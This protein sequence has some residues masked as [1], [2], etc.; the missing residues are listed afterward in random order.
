MNL[1]LITLQECQAPGRCT[2]SDARAAHLRTFLHAAPG[3][4]FRVG[5]VDGPVGV[6]TVEAVEG[7]QVRFT[8]ACS[9]AAPA[10]WY[11]LVLALP[12]PRSLRRILFQSAAMGVRRIWLTGAAKVE[13]SYF[14]MH[15]LREAEYRPILLEG[16]MQ[17][18]ATAMP[19]L[20]VVPR[21][22]D[23][24]DLLPAAS[25]LRIL[26]NPAPD[27]APLPLSARGTEAVQPL[28]AVGPDGGWSAQ[29][30][31]AFL[32]HGF[33]PFSLGPRP[34]RTDTAAVALAAVVRDR[35]VCQGL[36]CEGGAR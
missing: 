4:T 17:G 8:F 29:E 15:L 24:F 18:C 6:A 2:L 35:L 10:P 33:T 19:E 1:I 7:E 31:E 26:A 23:L 27:G 16:L 12:R 22:R 14:S 21:F 11:D 3:S 34:L 20:T 30:N 13:K 5:L 9:E 36:L 25:T 32:A 28:I